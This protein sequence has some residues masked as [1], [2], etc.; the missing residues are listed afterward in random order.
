MDMSQGH[1]AAC[2]SMTQQISA[3]VHTCMMI[4]ENVLVAKGSDDGNDSIMQNVVKDLVLSFGEVEQE[5][6]KTLASTEAFLESSGRWRVSLDDA[7]NSIQHAFGEEMDENLIEKHM[8]AL[9]RIRGI[10]NMLNSAFPSSSDN[11]ANTMTL[12]A[13]LGSSSGDV[14]H[15]Q[16]IKLLKENVEHTKEI[17]ENAKNF[18]TDTATSNGVRNFLGTIE[19]QCTSNLEAL[20]KTDSCSRALLASVAAV[21]QEAFMTIRFLNEEAEQHALST[22]QLVQSVN[23]LQ[24]IV[25]DIEE[26]AVEFD[27]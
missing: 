2:E 21:Q 1:L 9:N 20:Q 15:V 14:L 8:N 5:Y 12:G 23:A 27:I 19:Q 26:T 4:D 18:N 7:I 3:Y 25:D 22:E 13:D 11:L 17:I 16:I 24:R 6:M 10:R